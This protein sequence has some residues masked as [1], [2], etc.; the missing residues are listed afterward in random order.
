[1]NFEC[2]PRVL[3]MLEK[4]KQE[5][6]FLFQCDLHSKSRLFLFPIGC[7]YERV[8]I[9][10]VQTWRCGVKAR[11][12]NL[13]KCLFAVEN[14][15][16]KSSEYLLF[17]KCN[18]SVL[19]VD[20]ASLFGHHIS[21]N[22]VCVCVCS[23]LCCSMES[24]LQGCAF[25]VCVCVCNRIIIPTVLTCY[26]A[27]GSFLSPWPRDVHVMLSLHKEERLMPRVQNDIIT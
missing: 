20:R 27:L 8:T 21:M 3:G 6:N 17:N 22:R 23:C 24:S 19:R 15:A 5:V 18:K 26:C 10:Y 14:D 12:G 7:L 25:T 4:K 2:T 11:F 13:C 9:I 1:M 16:V